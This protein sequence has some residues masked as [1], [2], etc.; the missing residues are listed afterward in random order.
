VIR[1]GMDL[2]D[3]I[4][5][6]GAQAD[7]KDVEERADIVVYNDGDMETLSLEADRVWTEIKQR[8]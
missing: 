2:E 5:R 8:A 7:Q 1:R 3:V 6:M 4:A